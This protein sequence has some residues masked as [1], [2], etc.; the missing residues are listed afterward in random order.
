[1]QNCIVL[2]QVGHI[3]SNKLASDIQGSLRKGDWDDKI[4]SFQAD[5]CFHFR[6]SHIHP[7]AG[8]WIL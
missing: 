7:D 1:M 6:N 3:R 5:F 8:A 2:E 4:P